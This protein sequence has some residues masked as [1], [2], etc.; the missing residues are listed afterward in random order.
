MRP[1]KQQ[2]AVGVDAGTMCTRCVILQV[3]QGMLR[4]LGHGEVAHG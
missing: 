2:L 1:N 4:Y 3:N